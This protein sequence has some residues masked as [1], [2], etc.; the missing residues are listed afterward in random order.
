MKPSASLRSVFLNTSALLAISYAH[1][2][3]LYWDSNSTTAGAGATPTGTWGTSNFWNTDPTGGNL[4]SFQIG[5]L[6]D[7]SKT[8]SYSFEIE[9]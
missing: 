5:T 6:T 7:H 8:G 4:G 3:N 2:T 9:S 1:A